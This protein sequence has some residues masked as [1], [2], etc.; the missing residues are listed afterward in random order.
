MKNQQPKSKRERRLEITENFFRA[1]YGKFADLA[2]AT[3]DETMALEAA[4]VLIA[5]LRSEVARLKKE[6]QQP[7]PPATIPAEGEQ[8]ESAP[9]AEQEEKV[10]ERKGT[11]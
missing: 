9:E 1:I 6:L 10:T 4:T 3:S 8:P 5:G 2:I 7:P 11:R